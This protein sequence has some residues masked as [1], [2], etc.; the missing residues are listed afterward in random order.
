MGGVGC[1]T[2]TF[3]CWE[4]ACICSHPPPGPAAASVPPP[5]HRK[6]QHSEDAAR[7][8]CLRSCIVSHQL[9]P[10]KTCWKPRRPSTCGFI[11][12]R[13]S[14]SGDECFS[15]ESQETQLIIHSSI[16]TVSYRYCNALINQEVQRCQCVKTVN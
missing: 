16:R 1:H 8:C 2:E 15:P 13:L 6:S 9:F 14:S 3:Q 5:T 11:P 7:S 12:A 10:K 4:T